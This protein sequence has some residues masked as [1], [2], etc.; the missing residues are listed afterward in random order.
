MRG[1]N[2]DPACSQMV[3]VATRDKRPLQ[4]H[5]LPYMGLAGCDLLTLCRHSAASRGL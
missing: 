2:R 4:S 3:C 1:G 5:L